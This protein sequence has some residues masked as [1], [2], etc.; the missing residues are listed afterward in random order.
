M[1]FFA[2]NAC[3]LLSFVYQLMIQGS[4]IIQ[5]CGLLW[6]EKNHMFPLYD[7]IIWMTISFSTSLEKDFLQNVKM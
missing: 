1:L 4:L 5:N 7:Y 3:D 2:G 6:N